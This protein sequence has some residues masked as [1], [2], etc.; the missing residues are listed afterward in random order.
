MSLVEPAMS[1]VTTRSRMAAFVLDPIVPRLLTISQMGD[2]ESIGQKLAISMAAIF[3]I[4]YA[5]FLII[6]AIVFLLPYL[7]ALGVISVSTFALVNADFVKAGFKRRKVRKILKRI[8]KAIREEQKAKEATVSLNSVERATAE[9]YAKNKTAKLVG[10]F[11]EARTELIAHL[12]A[13][14]DRLEQARQQSITK[15]G[16]VRSPKRFQRA[17]DKLDK[18]ITELKQNIEKLESFD[19]RTSP[20]L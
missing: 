4:V 1:A 19:P 5:I 20:V 17:I 7:V 16:T 3:G 13:G 12:N 6:Q 10:E 14:I 2:E 15:A 11:E 18:K 9:S 8:D